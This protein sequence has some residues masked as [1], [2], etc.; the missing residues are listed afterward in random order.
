MTANEIINEFCD[1]KL[2]AACKVF[3]NVFIGQF[4]ADIAELTKSGYANE[5]E[6]KVTVSDFRRDEKKERVVPDIRGNKTKYEVLQSGV[7]VNRF[8]YIVPE[9][10]LTEADIP[11][12]AGL[13]YAK[14]LYRYY[15]GREKIHFA[16]IKIA[17]L[18]T[19]E[20]LAEKIEKGCLESTYYKFHKYRRR[21]FKANIN[22]LDAH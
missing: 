13:I 7:R 4:E 19:K 11:D 20:K 5:Y 8:Y 3:P 16:T 21:D 14:G 22:K 2:V 18:L 6:V 9:K 1:E 15:S 12:F 10:L 17:P